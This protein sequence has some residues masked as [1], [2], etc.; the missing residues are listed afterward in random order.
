MKKTG[1]QLVVRAFTLLEML[2]VLFI[3]SLLV[4][5]FVPNLG[6]QKEIAEKQGKAALTKV[7]Q[8]QANMYELDQGGRPTSY[9]QLVTQG[10][11]TAEQMKNAQKYQISLP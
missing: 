11:L 10:Y 4:I 3:I 7:V 2:I 9:E 8:T 5:L 6:K 1:N